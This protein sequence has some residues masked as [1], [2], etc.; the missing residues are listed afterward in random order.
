MYTTWYEWHEIMINGMKYNPVRIMYDLRTEKWET[1]WQEWWTVSETIWKMIRYVHNASG[2]VLKD[3]E[4]V[5]VLGPHALCVLM[6]LGGYS[7]PITRVRMRTSNGR[8]MIVMLC[9]ALPWRLL[10]LAGVRPKGLLEYAHRIRK[11]AT[12][13]FSPF[14]TNL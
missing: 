4:N 7:Y 3:N 2:V 1:I 5:K 9:I 14:V 10:V 12:R 6:H 11:M 13:T 8:T